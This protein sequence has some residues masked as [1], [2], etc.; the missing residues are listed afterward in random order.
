MTLILRS[1][2]ND[3]KRIVTKT[4]KS[5]QTSWYRKLESQGFKDIEDCNNPNRPLREWHSFKIPSQKFQIIKARKIQYQD[6]IENFINH[7]H[8]MEACKS[9]IKHGNCKFTVEQTVL[10][11]QLH[12][13]GHTTREI[14]EELKR[15]KNRTDHIIEKLRKWMMLL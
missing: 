7:P 11:W 12:V 6:Q 9:V 8:F 14:A 15:A 2:F 4:F 3:F 5:L 1:T 10:I 13:Q